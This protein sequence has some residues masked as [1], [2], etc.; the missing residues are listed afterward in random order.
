MCEAG[1]GV[2]RMQSVNE[3]RLRN[4]KELTRQG[5]VG[6]RSRVPFNLFSSRMYIGYKNDVR[7]QLRS[8]NNTIDTT[9]LRKDI[10]QNLIKPKH[11]T[12]AALLHN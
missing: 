6:K 3:S 4:K 5:Q 7:L 9:P 8:N 1:M 11:S 10:L 12:L 2:A